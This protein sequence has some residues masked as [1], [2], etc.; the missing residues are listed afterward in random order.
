M[1]K[2][3]YYLISVIVFMMIFTVT[4]VIMFY[5]K[6]YIPDTLVQM[7]FTYF[8]GECGVCGIIKAVQTIREN[9]HTNTFEPTRTIQND[10]NNTH[11]RRR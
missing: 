10:L 11:T 5:I 9:K 1:K 3:D 6:G 4:M 2:M 7:A 8:L